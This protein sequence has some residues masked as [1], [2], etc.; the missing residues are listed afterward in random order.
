MYNAPD[1]IKISVQSTNAFASITG[2]CD[3]E[4]YQEKSSLEGCTTRTMF[5]DDMIYMCYM[6]KN[7]PD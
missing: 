7:P 4:W 2:P 3:P 6:Q 5:S 1:F